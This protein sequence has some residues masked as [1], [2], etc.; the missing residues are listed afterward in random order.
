MPTIGER[1]EINASIAV[2]MASSNI[3]VC[4]GE[5]V[6]QQLAS[7]AMSGVVESHTVV[8]PPLDGRDWTSLEF[9]QPGIAQVRTQSAL[10]IRNQRANRG[11]GTEVTIGG[12]HLQQ[13][14]FRLD[15]VSIK[16]RPGCS[17]LLHRIFR[18]GA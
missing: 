11:L 10:A 18:R 13:N 5:V 7:S 8:D 15:G 3:T 17:N 12:N 6:D 14:N 1:H 2:G 4:P 16:Q 9:L